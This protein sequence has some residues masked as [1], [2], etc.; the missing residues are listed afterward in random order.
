MSTETS[1]TEERIDPRIRR[2]CEESMTVVPHGEETGMFDVYSGANDEPYVVDLAGE[3]D[4]CTC[5][6]MDYNLEKGEQCKHVQRVRI[7]FD[8]MDVPG[9]VRSKHSAPTDV[10]LARRRRG[11][12]GEPESIINEER[13]AQVVMAD[14]G[15]EDRETALKANELACDL[16]NIEGAGEDFEAFCI[17]VEATQDGILRAWAKEERRQAQRAEV[18]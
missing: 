9:G 5:P 10:E 14:G 17:V 3:H 13:P 16:T 15:Q 8:L 4:R 6:D 11:I 7:E 1:E 12:D 18:V 2:A